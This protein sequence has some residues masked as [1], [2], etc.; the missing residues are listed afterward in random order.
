MYSFYS[1]YYSCLLES[2]ITNYY[3][4]KLIL[5]I[6]WKLI[7]VFFIFDTNLF[8]LFYI[9]S[10][11]FR[12]IDTY[13]ILSILYTLLVYSNFFIPYLYLFSIFFIFLN[14]LFL[15]IHSL[16]F[17]F[18]NI[19]LRIYYYFIIKR[20]SFHSH[21]LHARSRTRNLSSYISPPL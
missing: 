16:F 12:K 17:M 2:I 19:L 10:Y 4:F 15:F 1:L 3:L 5:C 7:Y 6:F 13:S 14:I 21:I 8:F 9:P 20:S 18:I 11:F